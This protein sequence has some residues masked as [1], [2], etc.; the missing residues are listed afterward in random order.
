MA[1]LTIVFF[2]DRG[3]THLKQTELNALFIQK[4]TLTILNNLVTETEKEIMK[5]IFLKDLGLHSKVLIHSE[6][7]QNAFDN[8]YHST[9]IRK[10]LSEL[11]LAREIEPTI[12][13]LRGEILRTILLCRKGNYASAKQHLINKLNLRLKQVYQF[14]TDGSYSLNLLIDVKSRQLK[15]INYYGTLISIVI[16]TSTSLI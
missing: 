12:T 6:D 7:F 9:S 15:A 10:G 2:T 14:T 3:I 8:Y 5:I 13:S 4:H 11:S 1:F 16:T